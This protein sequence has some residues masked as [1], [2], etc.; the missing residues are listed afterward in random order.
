M[1]KRRK[2]LAETVVDSFKN[3]RSEFLKVM[4]LC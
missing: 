1:L 2:I 4:K 3:Q